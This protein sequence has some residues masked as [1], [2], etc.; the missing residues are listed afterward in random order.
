MP[1]FGILVKFNL[2]RHLADNVRSNLLSCG[3]VKI[4]LLEIW[5][6]FLKSIGI[7]SVRCG[8]VYSTQYISGLQKVIRGQR[9]GC[10]TL[11]TPRN[12]IIYQA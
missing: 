5:R 3:R 11:K 4:T 7:H 9:T 12:F 8:R 6:H 2:Q 10:F 1:Y